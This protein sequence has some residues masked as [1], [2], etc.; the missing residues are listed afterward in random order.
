MGNYFIESFAKF[1]WFPLVLVH[2]WHYAPCYVAASFIVGDSNPNQGRPDCL[3]HMVGIC[4][5]FKRAIN[6]CSRP[7]QCS[8]VTIHDNSWYLKHSNSHCKKQKSLS[9][10]LLGA[11]LCASFPF[12]FLPLK[13]KTESHY[14]VTLF[15]DRPDNLCSPGRL[16]GF[17]R[18]SPVFST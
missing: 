2:C 9:V 12:E 10:K 1:I 15:F 3:L 4:T 17:C 8:R 16:H 11:I 13:S 6:F 18:S 5:F 14:L 7:R